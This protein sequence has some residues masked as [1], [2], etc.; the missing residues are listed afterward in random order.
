MFSGFFV[1]K[2]VELINNC[3]INKLEEGFLIKNLILMFVFVVNFMINVL[4]MI[5]LEVRNEVE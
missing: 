5:W 3:L 4:F 2:K 1:K